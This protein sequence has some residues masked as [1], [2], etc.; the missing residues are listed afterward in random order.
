MITKK[1]VNTITDEKLENKLFQLENIST[2]EELLAA[3]RREYQTLQKIQSKRRCNSDRRIKSQAEL[4][5]VFD[6]VKEFVDDYLGFH[7][8]DKPKC[9]FSRLRDFPDVSLRRTTNI[10]YVL[11][12]GEMLISGTDLMSGEPMSFFSIAPAVVLG[13]AINNH[14]A[15]RNTNAYILESDRILLHRE[16]YETLVPK[17]AHEYTH[18]LQGRLHVLSSRR[19]ECRNFMEGHARGVQRYVARSYWEQ[20]DNPAFM[21]F[22]IREDTRELHL[23]YRLLCDRFSQQPHK[24]LVKGLPKETIGQKFYRRKNGTVDPHVIGNS[25]MLIHEA[26]DGNDIYRQ[27]LQGEYNF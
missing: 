22:T 17:L 23:A 20:K 18:A 27:M 2:L 1:Y 24:I 9:S 21:D 26:Q 5:S 25:L 19:K 6:E 4:E 7:F 14:Y 12:I 8:K 10:F 15:I 16:K 3:A 13:L 11:G